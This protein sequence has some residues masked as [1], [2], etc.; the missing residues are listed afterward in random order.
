MLQASYLWLYF[1][2]LRTKMAQLDCKLKFLWCTMIWKENRDIR[3]RSHSHIWSFLYFTYTHKFYHLYIWVQLLNK[4][5]YEG[6]IKGSIFCLKMKLYMVQKISFYIWK[7][8]LIR[9]S[10][11]LDFWNNGSPQGWTR[12]VDSLLLNNRDRKWSYTK[13]AS[14]QSPTLLQVLNVIIRSKIFGSYH[15]IHILTCIMILNCIWAI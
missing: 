14:F 13:Y 11:L 4:L 6:S 2:H 5:S 3:N 7:P 9:H 10:C 12:L 8:Y 1:F 15:S